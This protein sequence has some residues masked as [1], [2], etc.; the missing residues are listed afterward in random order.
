MDLAATEGH[1]TLERALNEANALGLIDPDALRKDLDG[2]I[3]RPGVGALRRVFGQHEFRFTRS[4]VERQFLTLALDAELPLPK[5]KVF[6][7]GFEVD[8]YWPELALIVETDSLT[9]H[10]TAGQQAAD[11]LRDQVHTAAGLTT[12]RFTEAQIRYEPG[13]VKRVLTDTATRL[14]AA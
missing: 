8:F 1:R 6:V 2:C 11:R 12:L 7:H 3:P 5:T 9:Y 4:G 10:R 14:A 13:H